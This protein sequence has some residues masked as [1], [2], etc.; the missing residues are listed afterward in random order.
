MLA[1]LLVKI[2]EAWFGENSLLDQL[3]TH[4]L[5]DSL[6]DFLVLLSQSVRVRP[7]PIHLESLHRWNC[8]C[9]GF[10]QATS[11]ENY[12]YFKLKTTKINIEKRL[13]RKVISQQPGNHNAMQCN[14]IQYNTMQYIY[15]IRWFKDSAY[16]C[17]CAYVLCISRYSDFLSVIL[18]NTGRF[19]RG[20]KLC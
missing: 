16:Y 2:L 11:C 15:L 5:C 12:K 20:L 7:R 8:V 17:Y 3:P 6:Q 13:S 1:N 14:T 10:L 4:A 19:L 9:W 18:T